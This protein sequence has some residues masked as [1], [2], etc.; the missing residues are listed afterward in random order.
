MKDAKYIKRCIKCNRFIGITGMFIPNDKDL[1]YK[2]DRNF[3]Y[4]KEVQIRSS[5]KNLNYCKECEELIGK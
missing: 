2:K 5:I 1:Q 3:Y 4:K